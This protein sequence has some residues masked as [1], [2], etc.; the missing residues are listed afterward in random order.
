MSAI[1]E[2]L[3]SNAAFAAGYTVGSMAAAPDRRIAVLTCMDARLDVLR[4]LG[5]RVGDAHVLRNAGGVVTEDGIR[6]LMLSQRLLGTREV[7]VIQHTGCGLLGL[8]EK[9]LTEEIERETG[10]RL[11]FALGGFDD[12]EESVRSSVARIR[13]TP[14]LPHREHVRGFIYD[15]G[16]GRLA[17]V[18]PPG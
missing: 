4:M 2:V 16:T 3:R 18:A 14:L 13:A 1:D 15:I 10:T 5:L 12:L 17:E 9:E 8:S 7:M 11:P 6:S